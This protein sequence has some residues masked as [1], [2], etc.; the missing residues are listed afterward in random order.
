[1]MWDSD[2]A[3]QLQ[4][5]S[6]EVDSYPNWVNYGPSPL[7]LW[8]R[9]AHH[10]CWWL[11]LRLCEFGSCKWSS[12]AAAWPNR[13]PV[14]KQGRIKLTL[15]CKDGLPHEERE[16]RDKDKH[17][18]YLGQDNSLLLGTGMCTIGCLA[19]SLGPTHQMLVALSGCNDQRCL[20]TVTNVP[21]EGRVRVEAKP[22]LHGEPLCQS[23]WGSVICNRK[24]PH[25]DP[26]WRSL[27][28][29]QASSIAMRQKQQ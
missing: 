6:W 17:Y 16:E 18:W 27:G 21:S 9:D 14:Y 22:L 8:F 1:M 10:H 28:S 7:E 23:E 15:R 29:P 24:G 4:Q 25:W 13:Q 19:V 2:P 11:E 12:A 20:Q 5:M 3:T 26:S